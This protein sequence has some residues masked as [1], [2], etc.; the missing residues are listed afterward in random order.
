MN[1]DTI[2]G[3]VLI[4]IIL[5]GSSLLMQP[6]KEEKAAQQRKQDSIMELR[7]HYYDSISQAEAIKKAQEEAN[8]NKIIEE[9]LAVQQIETEDL[10]LLKDKLGLFAGSGIENKEYYILENDVIK[11][12]LSS[13]GGRIF[14]V[15][16]KNYQTYDSLPLILFEAD[17]SAFGFS[18]FANN[19][20]INTSDL[21]F[22]PHWKSSIFEGKDSI[23]VSGNDSV[24][25]AMRLYADGGE[26]SYN[27]NKYIEFL[28][29]LRGNKYM[30]PYTI[31]FVGMNEIITSNP[32]FINLAWSANLRR[33][34]KSLDNE[35]NESTIYYKYYKDE[36]D[37]LSERSDKQESLK[38]KLKWISF[39]TR[40]FCSTLI[41]NKFFNNADVE[42]YTGLDRDHYCKSMYSE[43]SV[44]IS[45]SPTQSIPMRWYFGPNKYNILNS[46][47]LDL[48]QQIPLGWG[49]FLLAWV[50]VYA[51]IPVFDFLGSFGW[52][53]GIIILILTILIKIVLF[54]IAYKTY[55]SSAKMRV[56][57]PEIEEITKKFPKKEDA[58]K[59]QQAT[60]ALYKK[61]GV[62]PM[63]GCV[64]MLLQMP[65]LFAMFRFFPSSI[66]LRQKAFLWAHD[67]SSYDSIWTFPNG[68]K[69]PFYGDH[70][71]LFTLLMTV[72]TIFYT[73]INNEMMGS[74]TQQM[75]GMKTMM[76]F[77]PI[78]FLGIFNNYAS[79]LSYYYLL[80]N[81]FTFL[82]MFIF[83]KAI[84]ENKLLLQ[85]Q[86]N[87]KKTVKKSGFQK[88]MEDM[89]KKRGYNPKKK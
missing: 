13:K 85:I 65:I 32:G 71:S 62:N 75:P 73:K 34:E 81:V 59:K 29:T 77:M 63:A 27:S 80:A 11:I 66:E 31:N 22:K 86:K 23:V 3:F 9:N 18:F 51:V 10:S 19:R 46:Y 35:R 87:K 37:Y 54:P 25:F 56:L 52:N 68:F 79:A 67:L 44:P 39:K 48:E 74:S 58:M 82:Q 43:I 24:Q 6:S 14:S 5:V 70:V 50:N 84:N 21:Y 55:K 26:G 57:K 2:I 53:Y 89:A 8:P 49:F 88:R 72:S 60:M 40:F 38:S 83:R 15:Q 47:D 16:L 12:K 36:V 28:Y 4:F 76:Y 64:P 20:I 42:T 30:M 69:I 17:S 41:A 1:K 45:T 33:Q 78:M 7:Q 61:A